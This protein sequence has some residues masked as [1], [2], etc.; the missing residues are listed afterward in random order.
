MLKYVFNL[1]TILLIGAFALMIVIIAGQQGLLES[2]IGEY[3]SAVAD[4]ENVCAEREALDE[5][6]AAGLG[7]EELEDIARGEG[8][9]AED[10]IVFVYG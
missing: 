10:E 2:K 4:Y 3:E 9:V 5:E 6:K 1:K 7:S 8:Y